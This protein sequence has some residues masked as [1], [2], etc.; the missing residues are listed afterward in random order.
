MLDTYTCWCFALVHGCTEADV[1]GQPTPSIPLPMDISPILYT[2]T[3]G[4]KDFCDIVII[5]CPTG[6]NEKLFITKAGKIFE[7]FYWN[8]YKENLKWKS[9]RFSLIHYESSYTV[10][11]ILALNLQLFNAKAKTEQKWCRNHK[12]CR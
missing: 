6:G 5:L 3:K 8:P 11:F 9:I 1:V 10:Q 4:H 7:F 12:Y 2:I